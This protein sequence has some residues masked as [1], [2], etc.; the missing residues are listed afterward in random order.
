MAD[1]ALHNS[2]RI[3]GLVFCCDL[4]FCFVFPRATSNIVRTQNSTNLKAAYQKTLTERRYT[5]NRIEHMQ[6]AT[7]LYVS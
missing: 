4:L 2:G 1:E 7:V 6:L 5:K 3:F